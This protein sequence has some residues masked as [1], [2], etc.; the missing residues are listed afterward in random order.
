MREK[1]PN[2]EFF[3][4]CIFPQSG[5]IPRD[6]LNAGKYRPEKTRY[7]GIFHAVQVIP[8]EQ[9]ESPVVL[10]K[11]IKTGRLPVAPGVL[12]G[13]L[14]GEFVILVWKSKQTNKYVST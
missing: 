10:E 5:W 1:Y 6:T 14:V 4:V 2:T 13:L 11:Y 12:A 7:L 8:W 3:L 9:G